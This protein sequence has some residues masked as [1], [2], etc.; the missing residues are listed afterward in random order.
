MV[1]SH[2]WPAI[3]D[4]SSSIEAAYLHRH[5]RDVLEKFSSQY[6]E[7]K[8]PRKLKFFPLLGIINFSVDFLDGSVK[9]FKVNPILVIRNR[10]RKVY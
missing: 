2:Y 6:H 1:S 10:K 8:K 7:L 9:E 5:V 3:F 4:E